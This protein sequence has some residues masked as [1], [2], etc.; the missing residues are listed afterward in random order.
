MP[1]PC[2]SVHVDAS[3]AHLCASVQQI[4]KTRDVQGG[5]HGCHAWHEDRPLL[6]SCELG[7][8]DIY[9]MHAYDHFRMSFF[10]SLSTWA[11]GET[12]MNVWLAANVVEGSA[13]EE[14]LL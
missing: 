1:R 12:E 6:A 3:I 8:P 4:Q 9:S 7:Y 5:A 10:D 14:P 2:K 11:Q 13:Y